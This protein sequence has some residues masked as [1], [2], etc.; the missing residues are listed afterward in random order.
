MKVLFER[1]TPGLPEDVEKKIRGYG[2]KTLRKGRKA[3]KG[4]RN[5]RKAV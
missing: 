4:R 5:T 3:R 1:N 2:R